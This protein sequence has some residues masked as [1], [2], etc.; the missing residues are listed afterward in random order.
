MSKRLTK[1]N[2][3]IGNGSLTVVAKGTQTLTVAALA[4]GAGTTATFAATGAAFGDHVL[5]A[6]RGASL[7]GVTVNAYVDSAGTVGV[8]FQNESGGTVTLGAGT[9]NYL[10]VR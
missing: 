5:V 8:R 7:G 3:L 4:D 2:V 6:N 1:G 10:V 9:V